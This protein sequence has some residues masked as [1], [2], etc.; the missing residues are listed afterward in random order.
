MESDDVIS[1]QNF[2]V[3]GCLREFEIIPVDKRKQL[4]VVKYNFNYLSKVKTE[5]IMEYRM[6]HDQKLMRFENLL[7][8]ISSYFLDSP[9]TGT[10][11]TSMATTSKQLLSIGF[12][13][14]R[15]I[16]I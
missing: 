7:G 1:E 16:Q 4:Q 10:T 6:G 5:K 15:Q 8:K 14:S 12:H 2:I 13:C 11:P 3:F 9:S